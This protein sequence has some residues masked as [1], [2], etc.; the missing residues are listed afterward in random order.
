M[1][2]K[3]IWLT[4]VT[5]TIFWII[6]ADN[7]C[8]V[9]YLIMNLKCL[10][11]YFLSK[12]KKFNDFHF[13]YE[14]NISI[15]TKRV[16]WPVQGCK[17]KNWIILKRF[18]LISN[19][20]KMKFFSSNKLYDYEEAFHGWRETYLLDT[21]QKKIVVDWGPQTFYIRRTFQYH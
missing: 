14:H 10:L 8:L 2:L 18:I 20:M 11:S 1:I 12:E 4:G 19:I 13:S 21:Y 3:R 9:K 5:D 6:S 17:C 7:N 16:P 15:V